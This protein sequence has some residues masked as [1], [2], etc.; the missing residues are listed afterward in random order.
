MASGQF[1]AMWR[2]YDRHGLVGN[3][4]VLRMLLDRAPTAVGVEP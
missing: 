2:Y 3:P 1:T 4:A